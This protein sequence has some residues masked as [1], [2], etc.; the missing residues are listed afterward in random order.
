MRRLLQLLE[1]ADAAD[2]HLR[3]V[4]LRA[5]GVPHA[6]HVL[7]LPLCVGGGPTPPRPSNLCTFPASSILTRADIGITGFPGVPDESTLTAHFV[8]SAVPQSG[9][10]SSS[11]P[12]LNSVHHA[13]RYA[14]WSNL[15]DVPTDCPQ[16]RGV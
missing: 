2:L 3:R 14:S 12:L 5:R 7:R 8:H 16:V 15:M 11:S 6:V 1:R 9:D 13:T 10:F 4:G